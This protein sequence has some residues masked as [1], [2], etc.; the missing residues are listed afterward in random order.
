MLKGILSKQNHSAQKHAGYV[1][2]FQQ[3]TE[4]KLNPDFW[5]DQSLKS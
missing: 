4:L 2:L 3:C 5:T 1:G